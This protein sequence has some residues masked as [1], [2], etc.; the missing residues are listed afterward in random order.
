MIR[1][2]FRPKYFSFNLQFIYLLATLTLRA[3]TYVGLRLVSVKKIFQ[4]IYIEPSVF[5]LTYATDIMILAGVMY[6]IYQSAELKEKYKSNTGDSIMNS[7]KPS[8]FP[9]VEGEAADGAVT[10]DY[11]SVDGDKELVNRSSCSSEEEML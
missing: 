5:Y 8:I 4:W 6:F 1:R 9:N 11:A 3:G 10:P 2:G 7:S